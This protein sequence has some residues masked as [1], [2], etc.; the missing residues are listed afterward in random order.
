[1]GT[2][3]EHQ[4]VGNTWSGESD[5]VSL[6]MSGDLNIFDPRTGDKPVRV[7]SVSCQYPAFF[8]DQLKATFLQAP[9]KPINTI[10]ATSGSLSTFLTGSADGRVYSYSE[11]TKNSTLLKGV[12]HSNNVSGLATSTTSGKVYS[13]GFD[14]HVRE[15]EADG[16]SFLSVKF[17]CD[18]IFRI[19]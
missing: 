13:I 14:D 16:S 3:V 1:M 2:G 5:L 7:L 8:V 12:A 17:R 4:Q 10:T 9:Q 15:I 11:S 6:S 18:L 19:I